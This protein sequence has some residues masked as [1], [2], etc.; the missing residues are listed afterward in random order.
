MMEKLNVVNPTPPTTPQ[1]QLVLNNRMLRSICYEGASILKKAFQHKLII[2]KFT[3][4]CENI[5][6]IYEMVENFIAPTSLLFLHKI[7]IN[8]NLKDMN[9]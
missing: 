3:E 4:F 9:E 8:N 7:I 6:D 5:D 1:T 2:P